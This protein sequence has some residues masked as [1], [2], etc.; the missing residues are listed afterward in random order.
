MENTNTMQSSKD[1]HEPH[2]QTPRS[3]S[4]QEE[5]IMSFSMARKVLRRL[6]LFE[7]IKRVL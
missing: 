6:D 4:Q 5:G 1:S 7:A 2:V 3:K